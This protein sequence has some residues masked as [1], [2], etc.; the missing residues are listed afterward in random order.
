[1]TER[2]TSL[3]QPPRREPVSLAVAVAEYRR[4][5]YRALV[6]QAM[7]TNLPP[8]WQA[9]DDDGADLLALAA[10]CGCVG[11]EKRVCRH[12]DLC[13]AAAVWLD[14]REEWAAGTERAARVEYFAE[15]ERVAVGVDAW[16]AG[17]QPAQDD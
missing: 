13:L 6:L 1:M 4:L 15:L 7:H 14:T 3:A 17:Q 8:V 5:A 12:W 11:P 16:I 9:T 2:L 10:G